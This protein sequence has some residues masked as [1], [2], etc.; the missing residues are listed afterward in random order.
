MFYIIH[1]QK[2][3]Y[4]ST[5]LE[6]F[7]SFI[8]NIYKTSNG[9]CINSHKIIISILTGTK[10]FSILTFGLKTYF[11]NTG[12]F[13]I[14]CVVRLLTIYAIKH[15]RV[16]AF[17][18]F[19]PSPFNF[20]QKTIISILMIYFTVSFK[21]FIKVMSCCLSLGYVPF[22]LRFYPLSLSYL[23]FIEYLVICKV[24]TYITLE[25]Q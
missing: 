23:P 4:P 20:P 10:S 5:Y 7:F 11:F 12:L 6:R 19:N 1:C 17:S 22:I 21:T 3:A 15:I 8:R 2:T 18:R 9:V 16:T 14:H 24:L 25:K 13:S